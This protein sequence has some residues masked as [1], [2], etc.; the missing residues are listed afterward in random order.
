MKPWKVQKFFG[1][2]VYDLRNRGLLPVAILLLVALVAVPVVISRGGSGSSGSSP[3]ATSA[4]AE[5]APETQTAVLAYNPGI[6]SYK[7]RL[8]DLSAKNPFRQQFEHSAAAASQ[9]NSTVSTATA[10]SAATSSGSAAP[11]TTGE[12]PPLSTGGSSG[13][14]KKKKSKKHYSYSVTVFAGDVTVP[15]TPFQNIASLT[16]LPSQESSV[17]VYY[18]LSSDHQQA[19]FLVSTKVD[20]LTGP[21]SCLPAPDDCSLLALPAGASED[22]HYSKDDKTYRIVLAGIKRVAK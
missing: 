18:G 1:D 9:L 3:E 22:L 5:P 21:G 17:V 16:P 8:N 19:L 2:V 11:A 20:G 4:S 7:R 10:S 12:V 13:G 6:R 15:L 14:K